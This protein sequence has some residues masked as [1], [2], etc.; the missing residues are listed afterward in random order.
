MNPTTHRTTAHLLRNALMLGLQA[1]LIA[2]LPLSVDAATSSKVA[3]VT[4]FRAGSNDPVGPP[5]NPGS[6]IFVNA[7]TGLMPLGSY[8]T[9][10][11]TTTVAITDVSTATIEANPATALRGFDT[12]ILYQVCSLGG[13][14]NTLNAI[15]TFLADGGKVLIFDADRC[16]TLNGLPVVYSGF[17]FP[18]T[19]NR[20]GVPGAVG[21]YTNIQASTLTTGLSLGPQPDDA[22]G[23]ANL[24]STLD[25]NWCGSITASSSDGKAVGFVQA[26]A[27]SAKGGL[28]IYEG[29]DFWLTSGPNAHLRQVFDLMLQQRWNPDGLP[30][31]L[32]AS[33]IA[34]SPV[35][36]RVLPGEFVGLTATVVDANGIPQPGFVVVMEVT[37]GPNIGNVSVNTTDGNGNVPFV[38]RGGPV[39]TDTIDVFF[40]DARQQKH[41]S[42]TASVVWGDPP[43]PPTPPA[44]PPNSAPVARCTNVTVSDTPGAC[45]APASINNGS[46]DPDSGDTITLTQSPAGPYQ[47]GSTLVTLT[48]TDSKGASSSCTG[49]VTVVDSEPPKITCPAPLTVE[50]SSSAGATAAVGGTTAQDNCGS[51]VM[52]CSGAGTSFPLGATTVTCTAS[53]MAKNTS[54]CSTTVT[55]VDTTPPKVSCV[56]VPAYAAHHDKDHD[57]HRHHHHDSSGY[58]KVSGSDSCSAP[59]MTFGGVPLKNGETI[60]ITRR[61][62]KPG[63]TLE[64]RMGRPGIKHF[65]VGPG[66]A[67]VGA[68]DAAGNYS[69]AVCP[70][71]PKPHADKHRHEGRDR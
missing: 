37:S 27:R 66:N 8:T 19:A 10:D 25:G 16:S 42:N 63:V 1:L 32:P 22:V 61:Y 38:Y 58:F 13:L 53:D 6:S 47:T 21:A 31:A 9:G 23:D 40:T 48:V 15:N 69:D 51:T 34:L 14:P 29:E 49:T 64:N 59:T 67:T 11:G 7:L 50:C 57:R 5:L 4:D 2:A 20:L 26:Y 68:K 62:G 43:P 36:Q 28:V 24:L 33:G 44:A 55:V 35:T 41:V 30:C 52:S 70:L 45:A 39:G 12:V 56:R 46:F 3:Y 71:P 18:F 54:S 65:L 60:K 17:T